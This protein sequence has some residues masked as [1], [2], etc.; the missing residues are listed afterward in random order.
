MMLGGL[1]FRV[2]GCLRFRAGFVLLVVLIC[3]DVVQWY[4]HSVLDG[5]CTEE[6]KEFA[7]LILSRDPCRNL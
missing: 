3:V 1:G 4:R 7:V 6:N 5:I 2:Q